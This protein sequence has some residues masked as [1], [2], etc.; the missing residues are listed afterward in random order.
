MF[1]WHISLGIIPRSTKP[2]TIC[3]RDNNWPFLQVLG[4]VALMEQKNNGEQTSQSVP[5]SFRIVP[6]RP[7]SCCLTLAPFT[8]MQISFPLQY[9]GQSK[10]PYLGT[11]T[12]TAKSHILRFLSFLPFHLSPS[13]FLQHNYLNQEYQQMKQQISDKSHWSLKQEGILGLRT[14]KMALTL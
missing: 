5:N 2:I 10:E 14:N 8:C 6:T 7:F 13:L 9:Q 1:R 12:V 11:R 4:R 3:S